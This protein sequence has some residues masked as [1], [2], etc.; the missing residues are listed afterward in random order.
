MSSQ[1]IGAD[2]EQGGPT[3]RAETL[4]TAVRDDLRDRWATLRREPDAG[5]ST[6]TVLVTALLV[7]AA[8]VVIAIIVAEVT[9]KA[10]EIDLGFAVGQGLVV[11]QSLVLGLG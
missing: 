3:S 2:D 5:Y 6:E 11:W 7:A 10:N 9:E 8:L 4:W 1:R